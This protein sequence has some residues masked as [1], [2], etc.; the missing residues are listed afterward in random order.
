MDF[1]ITTTTYG[2]ADPLFLLLAALAIEAYAGDIIARLPGI[3]HPRGLMARAAGELE[4]RLNRPQ[5]SRNALVVRGAVVTLFLAAAAVATGFLLAAAT[6]AFPFAWVVELFVLIALVGQRASGRRAVQLSDAL[7]RDDVED[8]REHL[9]V[10]S[11][12][13]HDPQRLER[14]D[15]TGLALAGIGGLAER[16]NS[17]VVGPVFWYILLGLPGILL[18]QSVRTI[19]AV[20]ATG[21]RPGGGG[22]RSGDEGDFAFVAVRLDAA[23]G[24]I[25]DKLAGLFLILASV[26]IPG[27][28]PMT[29]LKRLWRGTRWS[30][31]A[32]GGALSLT[33]RSDGSLSPASMPGERDVTRALA[34]FTLACL[35]NFAVVTALVLLRH[36]A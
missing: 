23:L 3:P 12:E 32:L 24:W 16:Y 35:I 29:A 5:R 22:Y 33:A 15:G 10:L 18:Q 20:V 14:L 21:N 11:G 1:L 31:T 9:R 34:V 28:R 19:A 7:G 27:A 26:F 30:V 13:L 4:A 36:A 17:A 25:P 6:R 8:A 2:V